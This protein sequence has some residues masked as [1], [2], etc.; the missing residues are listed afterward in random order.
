MLFIIN[1]AFC[2]VDGKRGLSLF[3]AYLLCAMPHYNGSTDCLAYDDMCGLVGKPHG[4]RVEQQ[5][6]RTLRLPTRRAMRIS[7]NGW[8]RIQSHYYVDASR[9]W[10]IAL[11]NWVTGGWLTRLTTYESTN[12]WWKY[13]PKYVPHFQMFPCPHLMTCEHRSIFYFLDGRVVVLKRSATADHLETALRVVN[14][15][16]RFMNAV[17]WDDCG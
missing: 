4:A 3:S 16:V 5:D 8:N 15:H 14:I 1:S 6:W 10:F 9:L 11:G 2:A 7:Q 13:T 12:M 17:L